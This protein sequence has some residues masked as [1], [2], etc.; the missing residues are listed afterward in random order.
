VFSPSSFLFSLHEWIRDLFTSIDG[1][2]E[3]EEGAA[4]DDEA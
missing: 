2:D 3:N 4:R 1:A